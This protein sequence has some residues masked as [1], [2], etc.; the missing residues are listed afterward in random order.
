MMPQEYKLGVYFNKTHDRII[1]LG[2]GIVWL[3]EEKYIYFD[4][5]LFE[6]AIG[7]TTK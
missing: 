4:F 3:G 2:F 6:L 7:R 1:S 5:L